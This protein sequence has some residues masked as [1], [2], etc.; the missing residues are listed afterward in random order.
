MHAL[1]AVSSI[2]S[3]IALGARLQL[4]LYRSTIAPVVRIQ[5][6]RS[7]AFCQRDMVGWECRSSPP[8]GSR[9]Q[10]SLKAG[11]LTQIIQVISIR[12]AA[13]RNREHSGVRQNICHRMCDRVGVCDGRG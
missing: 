6:R 11:S 4:F 7:G 1:S 3:V 9:P 8:S 13:R 10:A 2:S 5:V 12:V